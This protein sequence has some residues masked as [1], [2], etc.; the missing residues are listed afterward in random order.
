[1]ANKIKSGGGITSNKRVEVG[2][3]LGSANRAVTPAGAAQ[4]GAHLGNHSDRGTT[5]GNPATPLYGGKAL[6]PTPMGNAVTASTVAG[7]GGSRT[8]YRSGYQSQTPLARPM[9]TGRNT[10]AEF[11]PDQPG[12]GRR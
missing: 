12:K 3:R 11:G 1:M 8:V 6:N 9:S 5:G 4:L 10:L 2:V 7:P